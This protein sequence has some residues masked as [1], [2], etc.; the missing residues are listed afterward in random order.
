MGQQHILL[1][2]NIVKSFLGI[3]AVNDITLELFPG[4]VLA[5]VGENGAGKST[6]MKVLSGALV[7]D[8]GE[9]LV[10]GVKFHEFNPKA[11]MEKGIRVIYQEFNNFNTLNV[12]ENIFAGEIPISGA[13]HLVDQKKLIAKSREV[14][15]RV[16]LDINP[17]TMLRDLTVAKMQLVEIA[18][19]LSGNF[20]VMVM[21]EP[22]SA[23]NDA[24]IEKLFQVIQ[25]IKNTGVPI[26]YISHRL[27]EIFKIA[28]RVQVLRDGKSVFISD[29]N[30][31]SKKEIVAN[32]VGKG[33]EDIQTHSLNVKGDEILLKINNLNARTYHNVSFDVHK[34]ELVTL[35]GLMGAGQ[36]EVLETLFGIR[37]P[38]SGEIITN[39]RT[40]TKL[41]PDRAKK[42]G[43]AYVPSD[44]KLEALSLIHS[45]SD[46]IVITCLN[47]ITS[48]RMLSGDKEKKLVNQWIN[49]LGIKTVSSKKNVS[50]LSGGNQQKIVMAKWLATDPDIL[51]LNE[52]TRGVDVGAKAEIYAIIDRM[53][54]QGLGVIMV[55]S[56]L[57]EVLRISDKVIVFYE[58]DVQAV[59][60]KTEI[61]AQA[62]LES[63]LGVS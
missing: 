8:S 55:S 33:F 42:N 19:A 30:A 24:E 46:N 37:R 47:K 29:I 3:V 53:L 9:V 7:P 49:D 18:K 31:T 21:D 10:E 34:G 20:K 57:A 23:L 61:T 60:N 62:L 44:R 11:C 41:T 48:F 1:M 22:T 28:D 13:F 2:K 56:D 12:A 63:A 36:A 40:F 51:L 17:V 39:N 4:E 58:G 50:T 52:P 27:D 45:I 38:G 16:G 26:I 59:Y 35:Y 43:I 32:M 15:K 5:L 14:L 54:S 25:D 6:L